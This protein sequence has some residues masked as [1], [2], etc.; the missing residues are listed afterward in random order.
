MDVSQLGTK[1]G[2]TGEE[3]GLGRFAPAIWAI[4]PIGCAL[5][6]IDLL[7]GANHLSTIRF[8]GLGHEQYHLH[9]IFAEMQNTQGTIH[10]LFYLR[11]WFLGQGKGNHSWK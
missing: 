10:V 8:S 4:R 9:K 5:R 7:A 3:M 11:N 2:K 1:N 6:K